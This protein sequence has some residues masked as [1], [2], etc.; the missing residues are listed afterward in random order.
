MVVD[1]SAI[2]AMI[3]HE[4]ERNH[5]LDILIRETRWVMS[6]VSLHETSIVVVGKKRD[7]VAALEV[8]NFLRDFGIEVAAADADQARA[9]RDAY[10]RFGKGYHP[11]NLNLADCFSYALARSRNEPLLFKGDDFLKT[12]IVPAWRP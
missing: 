10:F 8:D 12:D 4:P 2:V 3:F 9:A 5:F 11:A 1:T 7:K 6:A